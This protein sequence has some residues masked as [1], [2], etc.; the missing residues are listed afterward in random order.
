[1]PFAYTDRHSATGDTG[2]RNCTSVWTASATLNGLC[3]PSCRRR[4]VSIPAKAVTA[5][6]RAVPSFDTSR[7]SGRPIALA[8]ISPIN[9]LRAMPPETVIR[10][11]CCPADSCSRTAR[12]IRYAKASNDARNRTP[13]SVGSFGNQRNFGSLTPIDGSD[14]T[15][16][17]TAVPLQPGGTARAAVSSASQ[18]GLAPTTRSR[19]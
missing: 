17:R 13:G 7:S 1:M 4:K 12:L 19:N 15:K 18:S 6:P 8:R 11:I 5:A 9:R 3:D 2:S 14:N 10:V 16:G